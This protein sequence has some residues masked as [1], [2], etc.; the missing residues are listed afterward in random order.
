MII[1]LDTSIV[2][3]EGY[4]RSSIA[5]SLL[6]SLRFLGLRLVIPQ[7]VVDETRGRHR[8]E[9]SAKYENYCKVRK[10]INRL[11]GRSLI[12]D[13][14]VQ[15]EQKQFVQWLDSLLQDYRAEI[16]PYPK[17]KPAQIVKASYKRK[18]PFKKN[19]EGFKDYLIWKCIAS[20]VNRLGEDIAEVYFL[21][22][23][24][25]DFCE[26]K[27]KKSVLHQE[28]S[29]DI[30]DYNKQIIVYTEMRSLFSEIIAPLLKGIEP[31]DIPEFNLNDLVEKMREE[32]EY[33]LSSYSTYGIEGL[34]FENDVTVDVVHGVT[35]GDWNIKEVDDNEY[36]VMFSGSVE[37]E[38]GGFIE[39]SDFYTSEYEDLFVIDRDWNERV[40]A[41]SQTIETPFFLEVSYLKSSREIVV[42]PIVL[43]NEYS[44]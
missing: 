37:I 2:I 25:H 3:K 6:K 38:A 28:L 7:V 42:H 16:L 41:V 29:K 31:S 9:L 11:V 15:K 1:V 8:L 40:V 12:S 36:L 21:T 32:V 22:Q 33:Y 26:S 43:E 23:N 44:Y 35:I 4:L 30:Q 10:D 5:S 34:S 39:K 17:L 14:S 27:D 13:F 24:V 20:E 18:K 19:G